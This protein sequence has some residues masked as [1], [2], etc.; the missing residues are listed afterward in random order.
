MH[1]WPFGH[2]HPVPGLTSP[3]TSNASIRTRFGRFYKVL[4]SGLHIL[5]PGVDRIAYVHSLKELPIREWPQACRYRAC[6]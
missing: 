2:C 1:A 4:G 3:S 6:V 5:I